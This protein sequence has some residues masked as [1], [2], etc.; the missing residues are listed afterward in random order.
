MNTSLIPN[1]RIL[2]LGLALLLAG[3]A[4]LADTPAQA[5]AAK[6]PQV[7]S[8]SID[9][10]SDSGWANP[11]LAKAAAESGQALLSHLQSARAWLLAGSLDGARDALLTASEF[12]DAME[13]TMPF[14]AV[15]DNLETARNKL[16]A[17]E[18]ELFYDDLLPIY[19]SIDDI[20]IYA[21]RLARHVQGKMKEAEAQARRGKS[22]EAA[23][24]LHA[25]S[26]EVIHSTVYLPLNYVE[27]QIEVASAAMDG[28]HP[29]TAKAQA[30]IDNAL[31]S[32]VERQFTVVNTPRN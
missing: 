25:V 31:G 4:V 15:A 29:D 9:I 12:A 2:P 3:T 6:T 14:V 28:D 23:Q 17:G 18:E 7:A 5:P 1:A 32:L 27:S 16:V 20:Q 8:E 21:P 10:T 26:E 24:T 30:A 13:R 22:Q 19:T 11:T